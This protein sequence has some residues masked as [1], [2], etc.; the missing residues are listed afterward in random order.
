MLGCDHSLSPSYDVKNTWNHTYLPTNVCIA[1]C[2]IRHMEDF[3]CNLPLRRIFWPSNLVGRNTNGVKGLMG[4]PRSWNLIGGWNFNATCPAFVY[5][6]FIVTMNAVVRSSTVVSERM[7]N[8]FIPH[9]VT[10]RN[11]AW[12]L[13]L[14]SLERIHPQA[15]TCRASPLVWR[16]PQSETS[17]N[18][19][20]SQTWVILL[21][22]K[23]SSIFGQTKPPNINIP[24][25]FEATFLH[26]QWTP[27]CLS[28]NTLILLQLIFL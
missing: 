12:N 24:S 26:L 7:M 19:E 2:L 23:S 4:V 17:L 15:D 11:S 3:T 8:L 13:W 6:Y 21:K 27:L 14:R 25:V 1:W 10:C 16:H 5:T 9:E 20:R 28:I 18:T 22:V